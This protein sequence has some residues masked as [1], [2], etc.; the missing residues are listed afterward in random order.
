MY[1]YFDMKEHIKKSENK[2]LLNII[3]S[4]LFDVQK[5]ILNE[6]PD[7]ES[8]VT[9]AEYQAV[10]GLLLDG[11]ENIP[12]AQ[13]P[14]IPQILR[15][16]G[17]V[18]Q[19]MEQVNRMH[20]AVIGKI[21]TA[22]AEAGI[23]AV[24][25]KGQITGS[26]WPN[27]L[28]RSPGDIDFLV[29]PDDFERTLDVL[30]RIGKVDR[31]L[32]HEHHGMAYVD[33]VQLEPH[34]KIHNYQC[35]STDRAMNE[36]ALKMLKSTEFKAEMGD[37]E[38]YVFPPTFESVFL[39]SHIV[40]HIYEE[41]LGLRQIVDYAM[42]LKHEYERIDW[43]IH[44]DYLKRI[45]MKRA[46]RI[47]TC[48]CQDYL[49]MQNLWSFTDKEHKWAERLVADVM[50]VGNFGRAAYVFRHDSAWHQ[51]QNYLWVLRRVFKMGFVCPSEAMWWPISKLL[52]FSKKSITLKI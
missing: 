13:R 25:M 42:L 3:S 45:R 7:F 24:F 38:V 22:L 8:I 43:Q 2:S 31:N 39:I 21:N 30:D 11:L 37:C 6:C 35:P 50:H 40:N 16:A 23:K 28:H 29:A 51:L 41:G 32:E 17:T 36:M 44:D 26:R 52:R 20:I 49:G 48:L 18:C 47:V 46:W 9:Q 10:Q 34:Y 12:K 33:G 15:L 27:P 19:Q 4:Y 1:C 5:E 14:P